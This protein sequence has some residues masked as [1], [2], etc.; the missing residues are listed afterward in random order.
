MDRMD[1]EPRVG[2]LER[3][4]DATAKL[5][6]T[7]MKLL[8]KAQQETAAFKKETRVAIHALVEAQMRSDAKVDRLVARVDRLVAALDRRSSNGHG[9]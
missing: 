6:Q 5:I 8:V 7:G 1:L 9:R 4:M 2:K 3:R